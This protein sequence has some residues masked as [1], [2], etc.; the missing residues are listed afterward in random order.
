MNLVQKL[1]V[2]LGLA[3]L[4]MMSSCSKEDAQTPEP[5]K[6]EKTDAGM[7]GVGGGLINLPA[8]SPTIGLPGY[9]S[10]PSGWRR[11]STASS[12]LIAY[13]TGTSSFVALWGNLAASWQKLLWKDGMDNFVTVSTS[14]KINLLNDASTAN[15][16]S[17][18]ETTIKFLKPGK[19]YEMTVFMATTKLF[20]DDLQN[21]TFANALGLDWVRP[22]GL[23]PASLEVLNDSKHAVWISKTIVFEATA[24]EEVLR[25][26]AYT[27]D[28]KNAYAHIFVHENAIKELP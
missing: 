3:G 4:M 20:K 28:N 25:F 18:V 9:N 7:R 8:I 1:P 5:V 21:A 6:S 26:T 2:A 17:A 11:S 15:K 27:D 19:K 23:V 12:D 13:P 24:T 14:T 16:R 22:G 10:Y